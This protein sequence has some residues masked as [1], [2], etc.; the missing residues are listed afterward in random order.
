MQNGEGL[1]MTISDL[2]AKRKKRTSAKLLR[3]IAK[4]AGIDMNNLT[5]NDIHMIEIALA[6]AR[7]RDIQRMIICRYSRKG[8]ETL[9]RTAGCQ[10][11]IEAWML[12]RMDNILQKGGRVRL[13]ALLHEA[14]A[15]FQ[16][17]ITPAL[18]RKAEKV[19]QLLWN[20]RKYI[21]RKRSAV[22]EL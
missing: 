8:R 2:A 18:R 10:N 20:R 6:V 22:L 1:Y 16:C 9:I 14:S 5:D 21:K 4:I 7:N 3:A 19:R 11:R 13:D 17:D 12:T 15:F